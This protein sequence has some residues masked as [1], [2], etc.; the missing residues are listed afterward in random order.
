[1]QMCG[2]WVFMGYWGYPQVAFCRFQIVSH[3]LML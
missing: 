1:M 2:N 3:Q